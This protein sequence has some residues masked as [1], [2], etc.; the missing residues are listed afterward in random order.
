MKVDE[1]RKDKFAFDENDDP[2]L[3]EEINK[4][5]EALY[6]DENESKEETVTDAAEEY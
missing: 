6:K 3:R 1:A 5:L 2:D 4:D